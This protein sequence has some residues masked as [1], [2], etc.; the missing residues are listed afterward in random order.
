M[1]NPR[2]PQHNAPTY[3]CGVPLMGSGYAERRAGL[4]RQVQRSATSQARR[5][6]FARNQPHH[7][8]RDLL[9][10]DAGA[11]NAEAAAANAAAANT[12]QSCL[13]RGGG[14]HRG[15]QTEHHGKDSTRSQPTRRV[16]II[17]GRLKDV[18]AMVE[19]GTVSRARDPTAD[20]AVCISTSI[21]IGVRQERRGRVREAEPSIARSRFAS[22]QA[23][24]WV[25]V[26]VG[27][28]PCPWASK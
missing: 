19:G 1:I 2:Y 7:Q 12:H 5:Q 11:S 15:S 13:C 3:H 4:S 14:V 6:T 21:S 16:K 17:A 20:S 18:R 25:R 28:C 9:P 10:V 27:A 26:G 22:T 8:R 24:S 23:V